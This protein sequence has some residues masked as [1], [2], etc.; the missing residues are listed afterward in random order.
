M[1]VVL[2]VISAASGNDVEIVMSFRPAFARCHTGTVKLIVGIIHLIDT[3]YGFQT[4]LVK[5]L[6]MSHQWQSLDEWLNLL[7]YLGKD[8]CIVGVFSTKAMNLTASVVIIL[9]LRL[10]E[11]IELIHYLTTPHYYYA[12]RAHR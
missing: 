4:T 10:D 3:K 11:G 7:P 8:W 6:V 9:W 5:C 2:Q 12:N 1:M